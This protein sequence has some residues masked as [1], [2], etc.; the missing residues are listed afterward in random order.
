MILVSGLD[1][2]V[3]QEE[4][5]NLFEEHGKVLGVDLV[6]G[7]DFGYVRMANEAE[8]REAIDALHGALCGSD[9]LTVRA[10]RTRN[11]REPAGKATLTTV[12]NE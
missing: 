11:Q 3:T 1:P 2:S 5:R 4:I 7:Q 8:G 12:V 6:E 10:A 9:K